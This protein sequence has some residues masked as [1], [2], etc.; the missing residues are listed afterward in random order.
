MAFKYFLLVLPTL[1]LA[2]IDVQISG[3]FDD[4]NM[5]IYLSGSDAGVITDQ[6][7]TT[8]QLTDSNLKNGVQAYFGKYPQDT[9]VRSPT[10]WGDLYE[11]FGWS[12]VVRTLVP[13][14]G[15]IVKISS[16]PMVLLQQIFENNS[17]KPAMFNVGISQAVA[18]T[19]S[20]KWTKGGELSIEQEI[21][22]EFDIEVAETGSRSLSY[23]SLWGETAEKSQ[24]VTVGSSSAMELMLQPGQ[25]VVAQLEATK[26]SMLVEIS[27]EASLSGAVAVNYDDVYKGHHF[28]GL[29]VNA[30]MTHGN[31]KNMLMSKEVIEIDFYSNAKVVVNDS[32][33]GM[34]MMEVNV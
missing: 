15:R 21:N 6:E 20:S 5:N 4:N 16:E 11:S 10:P 2:R 31:I 25:T 13:K 26:G 34:R 33:D 17:S 7:R 8:F 27:Y 30:V 29:D 1:A 3:K 22:Y 18:T 32:V 9:F 12:E 28:W 23:S 14:T 24:T 19:V